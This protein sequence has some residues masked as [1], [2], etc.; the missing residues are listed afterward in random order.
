MSEVI[1]EGWSIESLGS[2]AGKI[3]SGAT[4]KVDNPRYYG[5]TVPFLKIDDITSLR[6]R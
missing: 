1:P 4:P 5:G 3:T 6:G 2:L